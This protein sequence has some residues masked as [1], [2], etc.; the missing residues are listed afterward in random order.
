MLIDSH[1]HLDFPD[2]AE[3]L[4][5]FIARAEAAG[6]SRMVTISTRVA[7]FALRCRS[8]NDGDPGFRWKVIFFARE[9]TSL[10]TKGMSVLR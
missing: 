10:P 8:C 3:D 4:P 1:C 9:G 6:V 7:K 5:A 2:F